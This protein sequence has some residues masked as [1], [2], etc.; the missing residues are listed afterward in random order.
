MPSGFITK[1]LV[2]NVTLRDSDYFV[3][4][5]GPKS[6]KGFGLKVTK[7]GNKIYVMQYR[8]AGRRT[9]KRVTIGRH[10]ALTPDQSR[11]IARNL[12]GQI[13]TGGD[14]AEELIRRKQQAVTLAFKPYS[15]HF[16]SEYLNK[17]W[18]RPADGARLIRNYAQPVLKDRSLLDINKSDIH[19]VLDKA[20]NKTATKRA[21]FA[22]LRKL[23]AWS[24][25]RGDV[26]LSPMHGLKAPSA[27]TARDRVLS[28]GELRLV[29]LASESML[30][31]FG[32]LF[33]LLIHTGQRRDEVSGMRWEELDAENQ[34][35]SLPR[36]R[37]K[38]NIE[39]LVPLSAGSIRVL[40]GVSETLGNE[41]TLWPASGFVFSTTGH[42][43][44]S[45]MSK[46]KKTLDEKIHV[47]DPDLTTIPHWR[48]HDVRRT[49]ATGLQKLGIRVEVTE[50]IL[51]HKSGTRGGIVGVYQRYDFVDEK[52]AALAAWDR[53][54]LQNKLK[55]KESDLNSGLTN[56]VKLDRSNRR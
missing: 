48:I 46:A 50:A 49:V 34:L 41:P 53:F 2:D 20:E 51:N 21:L 22:V 24:V 56:V 8:I 39:H 23:F 6:V 15:E 14:P 38:N 18:K 4:D 35:W 40:N 54:L 29:C 44:V 55:S 13:A 27:V 12:A 25:D 32:P 52:R 9:P 37:A 47:S 33:N 3:W 42:S 10:G 43:P 45:G 11:S 31:P 28:N 16:V 19:R 17:Q 30:Y 36:S 7:A 1:S 5:D 26:A